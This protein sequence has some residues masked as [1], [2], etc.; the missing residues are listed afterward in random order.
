[1]TASEATAF[2]VLAASLTGLWGYCFLG[3]LAARRKSR[4]SCPHCGRSFIKSD[5]LQFLSGASVIMVGSRDPLCPACRRPIDGS[6]LLQGRYD[7]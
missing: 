3:S 5:E 7:R 2:Y 1:M 6:A 4:W